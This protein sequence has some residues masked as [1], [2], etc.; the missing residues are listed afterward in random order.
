MKGRHP[1]NTFDM[2]D[3]TIRMVC[4]SSN[5]PGPTLPMKRRESPMEFGKIEKP[6]P[7][8]EKV[9]IKLE[10][11]ETITYGTIEDALVFGWTVD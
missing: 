8:G 1:N 2:D 9:T 4:D 3:R 7:P 6:V 11:G 5:W 10:S